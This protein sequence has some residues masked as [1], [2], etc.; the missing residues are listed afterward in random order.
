[1]DNLRVS[2]LI[3]SAYRPQKLERVLNAIYAA[4]L[5]GPI[6]VLVSL[7][8]DDTSSLNLIKQYPLDAVLERQRNEYPGGSVIG[9]NRL[10]RLARY[11]WLATLADDTVPEQHWLIEAQTAAQ[12]LNKSGVIGLNDL[13]TDGNHYATHYMVHREFL[14]AYC[15]GWLIHPDYRSWWFDVEMCEIAQQHDAYIYAERAIVEHRHYDWDRAVYDQT[16]SD[17][18]PWHATDRETYLT[19]QAAG[20]PY[21]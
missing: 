12:Q 1:M 17:S 18:L 13:H 9:W 15:G 11:E 16:Y 8:C 21:G 10:S 19:R 4:E 5:V 7:M 6:E 14:N 20:Y 2:I 3:P